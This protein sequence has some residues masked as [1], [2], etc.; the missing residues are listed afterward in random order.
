MTAQGTAV[1]GEAVRMVADALGVELDDVRCE[2][3]YAQTTADLDL[4]SWTIAAGCVAGVA[5]SWKG[6]VD[7]RV[8]VELNV[9]WRKG[10]TLEP[11]W[12][13]DQDGWVI[14]IDGRPTVTASIELP[15]TARLRGRDDRGLHG[16]GAHHDGDAARSTP[17]PPSWP[18]RRASPPTTTCRWCCP[19]GACPPTS[20]F[21]RRVPAHQRLASTEVG[22]SPAMACSMNERVDVVAGGDAERVLEGQDLGEA[23]HHEQGDDRRQLRP[24]STPS[25]ASASRHGLDL[26][27]P[28]PLGVAGDLGADRLAVVG[29]GHELDVERGAPRIGVELPEVAQRSVRRRWPARMRARFS[30]ARRRKTSRNRSSIVRK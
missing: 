8:V 15:P 6:S 29:Q 26:G 18:P 16:A 24:R 10:Q 12:K 7:D 13:I 1:F 2:A 23:G 5:A 20:E 30:S 17:F 25:A 11:D 14:Q 28:E 27:G 4:G 19:V 9:R 3:E 21:A 22:S